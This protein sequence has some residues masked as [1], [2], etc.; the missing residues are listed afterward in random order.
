[1]LLLSLFQELDLGDQGPMEHID[2]KLEALMPRV[3]HLLF[4]LAVRVTVLSVRMMEMAV[5]VTE[6][7]VRVIE[8]A[9]M[10]ME[11]A[12]MMVEMAVMMFFFFVVGS[13]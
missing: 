11:M 4:T 9:I 12:V 13:P 2:I 5:M 7:A 8:M 10:M 1:M 6:M 3:S